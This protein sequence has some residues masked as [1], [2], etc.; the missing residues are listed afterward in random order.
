MK[1]IL[2]LSIWFIIMSMAF[3]QPVKDSLQAGNIYYSDDDYEAAIRAYEWV[4]GQ[5]FEAPELYYNLGNAYFKTNRIPYAILNYERAMLLDP[6]NEDIQYNLELARSFIVDKI[7]EVPRF[8][9]SEWHHTLVNLFS[10]DVWAYVSMAAFLM[11]LF[12]I[13]VYLYSRTYVLKKLFFWFS[14]ILIYT[15]ISSF[16]FSY[17]HKKLI[18]EPGAGI[19]TRPSVTVESSPDESG[20]DLFLVHEGTKV[21][22]REYVGDWMR[23]RLSDGKEGWVPVDSIIE[24]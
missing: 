5:G 10:S 15:T 21:F 18:E 16:V 12:S 7:E 24:I 4:L 9:I 11:F 23:I 1:K 20:T 19:V 3:S 13:S 8:F 2:V 17:H 22:I 14:V 6:G